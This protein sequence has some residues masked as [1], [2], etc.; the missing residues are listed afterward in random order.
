M[1][2]ACIEF[3]EI[4]WMCENKD[5]YVIFQKCESFYAKYLN[6]KGNF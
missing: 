3:S 2:N 5:L 1:C 4:E 6:Y